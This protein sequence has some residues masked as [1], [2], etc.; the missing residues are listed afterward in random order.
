MIDPDIKGKAAG[1]FR[2]PLVFFCCDSRADRAAR[3]FHKKNIQ[4]TPA[5]GYYPPAGGG[6]LAYKGSGGLV[7]SGRKRFLFLFPRPLQAW[8][9]GRCSHPHLSLKVFLH[10]LSQLL[11]KSRLDSLEE[12]LPGA[13]ARGFIEDFFGL[14]RDLLEK[15]QP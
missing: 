13:S 10:L 9:L 1:G 5:M 11:R 4:L 2:R 7:K 12:K 14:Q 15:T 6:T 8:D 3:H